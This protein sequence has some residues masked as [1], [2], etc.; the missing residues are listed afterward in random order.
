MKK[1]QNKTH[2]RWKEE[3]PASLMMK[4]Q[5]LDLTED[6]L[7]DVEFEVLKVGEYYD[8]RY[9]KF[10]VTKD[11][12]EN[13][14]ANFDAGVLGVDVAL[15]VGHEWEKG[16]F[17]W[18]KELAVRG[19][20]LYAKFRDFTEEGK[21]FFLQ[22]KF[23]YFSVEFAPFT[24][25]EAGK[26][27]TIMDV[28]KGIALTNRPVIKG[29]QPTFLSEDI[30]EVQNHLLTHKNNMHAAKLFA[31]RLLQ[32]KAIT[33]DDVNDL[34]LMVA[35]LDEGDKA[36]VEEKVVEVEAKAK[37]D[38]DAAAEA[39]KKAKEGEEGGESGEGGEGA[40]E[41]G[42]G[43]EGDAAK[44]GEL[45]ELRAKAQRLSELEAKEAE[46][47]LADY[48]GTL[49]LSEGNLTGFAAGNIESVKAFAKTLS[50]DQRAT[51]AS[52]VKSVVT[53][54]ESQLSELGHGKSVKTEG[55]EDEKEKQAQAL[56]EKKIAAG[57]PAHEAL[58]EAYKE[59]G[60][61]Q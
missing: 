32:R 50:E 24:K 43:G 58:A 46:R 11:R 29:M 42:K 23:R 27:K 51:F 22:K 4:L 40:G 55:D 44:E 53:V 49:T 14:K 28:L 34:K 5:T 30:E 38:A 33:A 54:D 16:A 6:E 61:I 60:L 56:S 18:V 7:G 20:S 57:M 12:L 35:T 59:V 48:V 36:D 41:E 45:S 10:K 25:V 52:L 47:S 9:G 37:A 1:N 8:Q 17:A 31:E 19:N 13:L 39:E 2:Q 15:D 26:Q 3:E 21:D